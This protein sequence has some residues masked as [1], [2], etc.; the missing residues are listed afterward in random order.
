MKSLLSNRF[1]DFL[2][3]R[4]LV[5]VLGLA[6]MGPIVGE[7]VTLTVRETASVPGKEFFVGDLVV[8]RDGIPTDI[9]AVRIGTTPTFKEPAVVTPPM[10]E[11]AIK[12]QVKSCPTLV[13]D[14]AKVCRV[15]RPSR[16]V[17][18]SD[19]QAVIQPALNR[20]TGGQGTA[21]LLE[22]AGLM[23]MEIPA[24]HAQAAV[25]LNPNAITSEWTNASVSFMIDGEV[26]LSR[27]IRLHWSW[28]R[29]SW[30]AVHDL[31]KG[32]AIS[33][34]DFREAQTN[35]LQGKSLVVSDPNLFSE[36]TL[37]RPLRLGDV[38]TQDVIKQAKI[39][40][41]G[42]KVTV[43]YSVSGIEVRMV[44]VALEDGVKGATIPVMNT[45]SRSH[46]LARIVDANN[47][48]FVQPL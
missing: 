40:Y 23:P 13:W 19:L 31:S 17:T 39:V 47:L 42:G 5:I 36:Y 35:A 27:S 12:N 28:I 46:L 24:G 15:C 21:T 16:F 4:V 45:S 44:G 22:F 43:H 30:V 29:N 37:A 3:A 7:T 20:L 26:V 11:M 14:G 10:I 6:V 48:E 41:K 9:L 2:I 1:P 38:L 32:A 33:L 18:T 8:I 34:S 25:E